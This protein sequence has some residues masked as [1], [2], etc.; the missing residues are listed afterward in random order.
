MIKTCLFLTL[1]AFATA[2]CPNACSGHGT[3]GSK[4]SCSCYQNHQGNDCSQRTC[5]FGIAHVDTPKGDL[6]ADGMVSGPL[7][8]VIT[9]SE[10]YPWGTTEQYPNADANEGHFYMECSNKGICDRKSGTCDCFDGYEGTA[11]VRASGPND[12]SGHGT[13]ESIKELAEMKGYNTNTGDDATTTPVGAVGDF[14]LAIEESYAYDLW[15]QDKTMGCKCDPVY[16]G[17]DCS[18]KKCKYGVDPLFYDDSDGVI[19]QTTVVHLGSLGTVASD[20]GGTFN[21]VFYDVFGE[22]YVTKPI[23]ARPMQDNGATAPTYGNGITS[24]KVSEALE[25]LPNGVISQGN[26]DVTRA[27]SPAVSVSM[28]SGFGELTKTGTI[29]AGSTDNVGS[30]GVGIGTWHGHGPEF[31]ITFSTN[32]GILKTIELDTRQ[33]TNTGVTDYWVANMRQGAFNSRYSTNLGRINTLIYGSKYLYTN[34]DLSGSVSAN[35]LVKVGGQ[36]F[37][38]DDYQHTVT[39]DAGGVVNYAPYSSASTAADVVTDPSKSFRLT[40]SEPFLGT[41][42]IP[43]LTDTGAVATAINTGGANV[44]LAGTGARG[45]TATANGG[46]DPHSLPLITEAEFTDAATSTDFLR[47][48]TATVSTANTDSLVSGNNLFV[49]GCPLTSMQNQAKMVQ[50]QEYL[51]IFHSECQIDFTNSNNPVYRRSDDPANQN[52]Y[53]S[54]D[55]AKWAAQSYCFMR[56]STMVYPCAYRGVAGVITGSA[57]AGGLGG[58][59]TKTAGVDG[60]TAIATYPFVFLDNLGPYKVTAS[61]SAAA[62]IVGDKQADF[63]RHWTAATY[64]GITGSIYGVIDD[65]DDVAAGSVMLIN[66]RR[67]KVAVKQSTT[68]LTHGGIA[69]TETFA[70]SEYLELCSSCITTVA[71]G[72]NSGSTITVTSDWGFG[73]DLAAGEQIMVGESTH[74]DALM[75]V[76]AAFVGGEVGGPIS[77]SSSAGATSVPLTGTFVPVTGAFVP[78]QATATSALYKVLNTNGYKPILVT[79][80]SDQTTYQYVSQCSNR[81]ACDG[82]TGICA[83]FKGYTNDNCDTQNMLAA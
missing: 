12:C 45:N 14:D 28:A 20:I 51:E 49:Q 15:D 27:G 80:K 66:G 43:V 7:T 83:C 23:D 19:Y 55:T 58:A 35:S 77:V 81:G 46:T 52:M 39:V 76:S 21:I 57:T 26:T 33:I 37:I 40:L 1:V 42:I 5:Y 70:G 10:V 31:T 25:A 64:T 8:T 72:T 65:G 4:D 34:E 38:V 17:A 53:A 44:N 41:S 56:G 11:C 54:T 29:G 18:L 48:V 32:P 73:F 3:C 69:L 16:Y 9:G 63:T 47:L 82:S 79:E 67:Y 13:C 36:E 75:S 68:L 50:A 24:L 2:E 59:V 61:T 30:R 71:D 78:A 62:S 22:K 6:N 74:F 60:T